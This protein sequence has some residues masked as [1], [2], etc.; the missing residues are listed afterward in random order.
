MSAN[1]AR[2]VAGAGPAPA[3]PTRGRLAAR[4]GGTA[5]GVGL[6]AAAA[7]YVVDRGGASDILI[8]L[9]DLG[10]WRLGAL[11]ALTLA[12]PV[13]SASALRILTARYGPIGRG[14]MLALVCAAWL[15]NY[16]PLR[17]GM[18]AR[19]AYHKAVNGIRVR[20]SLVA[21]IW[22]NAL[23]LA[24]GAVA[25]AAVGAAAL[26][27]AGAGA[28]AGWAL[29]AP[30]PL[31][32]V[33][34]WWARRVR[35]EPDPEVWRPIAALA[36]RFVELHLWAGRFWICFGAVGAPIPWSAALALAAVSFFAYLL[37][38]AGNGLAAREWAV[39][40][41][42]SLL[43]AGLASAPLTLENGLAA[44]LNNRLVEVALAV[45]A[46]LIA[47]AWLASSRRRA[48]GGGADATPDAPCPSPARSDR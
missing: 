35:P 6:V 28:W 19:L 10:P 37:P 45:P 38:L 1:G 41:A 15:V 32:G 21:L 23:S 39:G 43:P 22:A 9:L 40:L 16:L 36:L 20:D 5:L 48:P 27:P 46:G 3:A 29:A 12:T 24:C 26:A 7:W 14:E 17:P 25:I 44:D 34:A 13:L 18:A 2:P 11:A 42:A 33:A 31:L 8:P 47:I 30:A 4:W